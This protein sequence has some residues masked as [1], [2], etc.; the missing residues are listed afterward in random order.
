[1]VI[2]G[3]GVAGPN[4]V[5]IANRNYVR[6]VGFDIRDNLKVSDGSGIRVTESADHI[7]LRNNRDPPHHRR[8]R[9]GDHRLRHGAD[10]AA[11]PTW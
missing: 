9:D 1:M 6:I 3:K 4:V 8:Q 10:A 2:S 11:S 7:E 5:F